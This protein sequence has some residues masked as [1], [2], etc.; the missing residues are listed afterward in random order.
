MTALPCE[1]RDR[2]QGRILCRS[3]H[4]EHGWQRWNLITCETGKLAICE[5]VGTVAQVAGR[6]TLQRDVY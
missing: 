2:S 4:G 1:I 3:S 6:G 5:E